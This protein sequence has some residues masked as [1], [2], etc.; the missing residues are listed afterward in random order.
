[1]WYSNNY[2]I[3]GSWWDGEINF[4]NFV[5]ELLRVMKTIASDGVYYYVWMFFNNTQI[6]RKR[7]KR[8]SY[9][10]KRLI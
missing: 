1:M 6:K 9:S 4:D 10:F 7:T 8:I 2:G 5:I 3:N